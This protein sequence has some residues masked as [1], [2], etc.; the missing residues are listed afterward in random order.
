MEDRP[1]MDM[2]LL[3]VKTGSAVD[4]PPGSG[5][6]EDWIRT[7]L[8]LDA[9]AVCHVETGEPL[10]SL[11]EI[12]GIIVTGSVKMVTDRLPWSE[13]TALWLRGAVQAGEPVLGICYGHQLLAHALG[14]TVAPDPRGRE[15]GTVGITLADD[16]V[17]DPLFAG[18]PRCFPAQATHCES[19]VALPDGATL[20][21]S[22]EH[23]PIHAF[24]VGHRA[25][26]VQFHPE[27]GPEVLAAYVRVRA[28]ALR[29]E[30]LDPAAI[31]AGIAATPVATALLRRF[32]D[33]VTEHHRSAEALAS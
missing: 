16:A 17:A 1:S 13:R 6:F 32:A 24:R 31:A 28:E 2:P 11:D 14:G 19:V 7:G 9:V 12:H 26:G 4:L 15:I 33:I 29:A 21:A 20:L 25:W 8:G 22:S 3:I 23:T 18:S 30:G 27:F 5:D 10:P